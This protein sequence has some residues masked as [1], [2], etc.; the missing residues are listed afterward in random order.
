V[1]TVRTEAWWCCSKCGKP[2]TRIGRS[3]DEIVRK[4]RKVCDP[5]AGGV[6]RQVK[7]KRKGS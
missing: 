7:Q 1:T 2:L 6:M 3:F 5:L 4:H